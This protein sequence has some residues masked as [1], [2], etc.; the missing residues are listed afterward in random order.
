MTWKVPGQNYVRRY[1]YTYDRMNR[2]TEGVY[3]HLPV[4]NPHPGIINSTGEEMLATG[5]SSPLS[6]IPVIDAPGDLIGPI[7]INAA[8]QYTERIAYDKNSNITSLERYGMNNQRHYGLIDSLVITRDGNQLKTIEDYA[9]KDLTY[10][11]ASDFFDSSTYDTEYYYNA[12]GAL[13]SDI[14]RDIDLIQYDDLGNTRCIYYFG[15]N[16][17]EYVYAADGTKLRTIHRPAS[18]TALTDS[19][20]YVGNLIL[21]NGQPSM[22]LFDGGYATFDQ[23][24]AVDGWHYYIQDYLGNNRMVVNK[25]GTVE[26]VT[27]Y[28]PYGGVIGDISTNES[29]QA[30]KFEGKELDRTFGLDNYDI[31]ARQYF[32]MMPSWDRIDPL[33]E[34]TPQF[35][36]YS[37]CMGDPVNLGDYNGK[38]AE[39]TINGTSITINMAIVLYGP[40][41]TNEVRDRFQNLFNETWGKQKSI[42]YNGQDYS[43]DWHVTIT[44]KEKVTTK[45][46]N[47]GNEDGYHNY[48]EIVN[49]DPYDT[50]RASHVTNNY[51]GQINKNKYWSESGWNEAGDFPHEFGHLLG[52]KDHYQ[53]E[54]ASGDNPVPKVEPGWEGEMM[55]SPAG[56]GNVTN[57]TLLPILGPLINQYNSTLINRLYLFGLK[58]YIK[59]NHNTEQ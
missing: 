32:A 42:T 40:W 26:Q 39:I 57:K 17:I 25:N 37:Y 28:Y 51:Y 47:K 49:N 56:E 21:K 20:D 27:H 53:Y 48:L 34:D 31:H 58:Y 59:H 55:S 35:S 16:Q 33:A 36:P 23:N 29:L 4:L 52:L 8:D 38:N 14:N 44:T 43:I 3:S 7:N 1:N 18:S 5:E 12:N 45:E 19:I 22:Y 41:A 6:L 46:W 10:T 11:G 9:E 15:H 2:L 54:N 24:G 13:E 50:Q 30:Y